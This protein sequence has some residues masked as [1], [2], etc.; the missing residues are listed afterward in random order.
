[1]LL[2]LKH[3]N[4][5]T[6]SES[7]AFR[8]WNKLDSGNQYLN[9]IILDFMGSEL[10]INNRKTCFYWYSNADGSMGLQKEYKQKIVVNKSEGAYL[11][12]HV[13]SKSLT[14]REIQ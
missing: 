13:Y 5:T 2:E 4:M 10:P 8:F 1:M 6:I 14:N 3:I 9:F 12:N 7:Q 11:A